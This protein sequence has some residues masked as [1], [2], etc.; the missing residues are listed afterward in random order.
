MVNAPASIAGLLSGCLET[1]TE[2]YPTVL[3]GLV[4]STASLHYLPSLLSHVR[5]TSDAS[6]HQDFWMRSILLGSAIPLQLCEH[7]SVTVASA[8]QKAGGSPGLAFAFLL[9]A[10]AIN[11]SLAP[12]IDSTDAL[13]DIGCSFLRVGCLQ[14]G[15]VGW[16]VKA[17]LTRLVS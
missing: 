14:I 12:C 11:L 13:H 7:T 15:P 1:A 4:L 10:P 9:S 6:T 16:R 2:I 3:L 5:S 17:N 8:V